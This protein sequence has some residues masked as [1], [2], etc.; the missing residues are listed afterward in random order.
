MSDPKSNGEIKKDDRW[1]KEQAKKKHA[2][3]QK[4]EADIEVLSGKITR[5]TEKFEAKFQEK[6]KPIQEEQKT[7][8]AKAEAI[9]KTF[10]TKLQEATSKES[11]ELQVLLQER[12][13]LER[14]LIRLSQASN[15]GDKKALD[16]V[17][18]EASEEVD[19]APEDVEEVEEVEEE[20]DEFADLMEEAS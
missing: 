4:V 16:E 3:L 18:P 7:L 13:K 15:T 17:E 5:V 1:A 19:V 9:A 2:R 12:Q 14:G 20:E 10:R 11:Q 8:Q 6:I